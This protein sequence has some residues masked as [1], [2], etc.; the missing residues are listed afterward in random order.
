VSLKVVHGKL[1]LARKAG[2]TFVTGD[3][4]SDSTMTFK[5]TIASV[6]AALDGLLYVPDKGFT[7]SDNLSITANDRGSGLGNPLIDTKT[8]NILVEDKK[9]GK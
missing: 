1:T 5:G 7:G 2:L 9:K 3:G 4:T 8:V 6:N